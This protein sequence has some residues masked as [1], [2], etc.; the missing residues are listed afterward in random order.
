MMQLQDRLKSM[1]NQEIIESESIRA[2]LIKK[3]KS[4]ALSI[5]ASTLDDKLKVYEHF[6]L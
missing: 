2:N 6:W 5:S 1:P 3:G 4:H